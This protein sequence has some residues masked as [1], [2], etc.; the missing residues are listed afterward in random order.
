MAIMDD[1]YCSAN[2][3]ETMAAVADD[4]R[5][6]RDTGADAFRFA[7]LETV[8]DLEAG[9]TAAIRE[10]LH[11]NNKG[12]MAAPATYSAFTSASPPISASSI[13]IRRP[14]A[15]SGSGGRARSSAWSALSS[16]R[17]AAFVDAQPAAQLDV[18]QALLP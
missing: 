10:F 13:S 18:R 15:P 5:S 9:M 11:G 8:H 7:R 14:A 6:S 17:P 12:R 4:S 1:T 2:A 16:T 3:A